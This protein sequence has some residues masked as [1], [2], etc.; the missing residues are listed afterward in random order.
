MKI[1]SRTSAAV[2]VLDSLKVAGQRP[3]QW[4]SL[5]G[6]VL[7]SVLTASGCTMCAYP[8]DY[9]GPV[10][11]GSAP[12]NDFQARSNGIL[13]VGVAP[14]PWPPLVRSQKPIAT[15]AKTVVADEADAAFSIDPEPLSE[16]VAN[17]QQAESEQSKKPKQVDEPV[18]VEFLESQSERSVVA[19]PD[20]SVLKK[21]YG[22]R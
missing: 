15:I 19:V 14:R 20:D 18:L 21:E 11:N 8:F 1:A 13:P 17:E 22:D 4:L 6:L 2:S 3:P 7:I 12:Q 10:P 16:P 5:L 9:S